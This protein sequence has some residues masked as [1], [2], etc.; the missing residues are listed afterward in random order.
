[1]STPDFK[2][3]EAW[4][5]ALLA[6]NQLRWC[7]CLEN[8]RDGGAWWAAVCGFAQSRTRLKWLTSSSSSGKE[9]SCQHRRCRILGFNP[10]VGKTPWSRKW[11]PVPVFLPVKSHGQRSLVGYS[12]W[13]PTELDMTEHTHTSD[14]PHKLLFFIFTWSGAQDPKLCLLI[15]TWYE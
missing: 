15:N 12:P 1:M 13:G 2:K 11:K 3:H 4:C 10:W 8:P 7:S 6:R 14:S 9:S 5:S